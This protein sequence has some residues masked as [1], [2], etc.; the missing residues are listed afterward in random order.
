MVLLNYGQPTLLDGQ[1]QVAILIHML[2][3]SSLKKP[4]TP[5]KFMTP[6]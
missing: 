2:N 1:D 5:L 3:D 6:G 4:W